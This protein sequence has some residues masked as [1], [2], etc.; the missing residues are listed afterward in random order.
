M[1]GAFAC[2]KAHGLQVVDQVSA[3][4]EQRAQKIRFN[5][6]CPSTGKILCEYDAS[7]VSRMADILDVYAR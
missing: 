1:D 2:R 5:L 7:F 4:T 3:M 6:I